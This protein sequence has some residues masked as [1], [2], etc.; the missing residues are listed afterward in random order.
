MGIRFQDS[1]CN[2]GEARDVHLL[3]DCD[4][5][6]LQIIRHLGWEAELDT[7]KAASRP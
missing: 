4:E 6:F 5:I 3:G 2:K 1:R 7:L